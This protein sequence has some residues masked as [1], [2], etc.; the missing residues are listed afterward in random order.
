MHEQWIPCVPLPFLFET[1]DKVTLFRGPHPQLLL[2][3]D[4]RLSLFLKDIIL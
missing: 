2:V 4:G 1:L 3:E